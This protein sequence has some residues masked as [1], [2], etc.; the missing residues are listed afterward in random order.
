[1]DDNSSEV[2]V[3]VMN[4]EEQYSIWPAYREIPAGWNDMGVRGTKDEC[5]DHIEKVWTDM[6]PLSLR[7]QMEEWERNP[8]P[9]P[10]PLPE[11]DAAPLVERLSGEGHPVEIRTNAS[12]KLAYM[13]E[14][15]EI[16]HVHVLFP[17]TRGGTELGL[18][19]EE[20]IRD[21][22]IKSLDSGNEI[23]LEAKLNLDGTAVRCSARVSVPELAGNGGL[24]VEGQ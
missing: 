21:Q 17:E 4:H 18:A 12:D 22:A 7:K 24:S 8:P 11:D 13:R 20:E 1:M 5:L 2:F 16:G 9:A 23:V 19:L 3:V 15:L 10:E 14:R 6:R